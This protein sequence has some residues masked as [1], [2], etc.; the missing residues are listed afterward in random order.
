MIV[1][2]VHLLTI[3]ALTRVFYIAMIRNMG[4]NVNCPMKIEVFYKALIR[5]HRRSDNTDETRLQ[6]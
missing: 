4:E 6:L 2:E 1:F 3:G 5:L